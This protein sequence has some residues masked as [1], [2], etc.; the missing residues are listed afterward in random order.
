MIPMPPTTSDTEAIPASSAVIVLVARSS[1]LPS[2]SSVTFSSP[3]TLPTTARATS[4]RMP[5]LA[6]AWRACVVT[7]KSSGFSSVMPWR[8]R[9]IRVTS[10][11]MRDTSP[12]DAAVMVMSFSLARFSSR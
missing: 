4:G 3:D 7:V 6:S 1:V 2:C 5:P 10:A 8:A 12:V 9:S 11:M